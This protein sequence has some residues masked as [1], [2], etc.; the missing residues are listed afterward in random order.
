MSKIVRYAEQTE[1]IFILWK[2][3]VADHKHLWTIFVRTISQNHNDLYGRQ[4]IVEKN[5]KTYSIL[6]QFEREKTCSSLHLPDIFIIIYR[7]LK[8]R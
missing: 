2:C 5:G 3:E 4:L 8:C 7:K 1:S 6:S